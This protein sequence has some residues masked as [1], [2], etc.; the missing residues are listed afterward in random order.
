MG[1][2]NGLN[3]LVALGGA[4]GLALMIAAVWA[5]GASTATSLAITALLVLIAVGIIAA[6]PA[7]SGPP[8][9]SSADQRDRMRDDVP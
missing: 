5:S 7:G 6:V 1:N 9:D 2:G 4:I 3:M 8:P